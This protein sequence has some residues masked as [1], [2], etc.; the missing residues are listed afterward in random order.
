M[1]YHLAV[2]GLETRTLQSNLESK[3][4]HKISGMAWHDTP[5][6]EFIFNI[7][8]RVKLLFFIIKVANILTDLMF[9]VFIPQ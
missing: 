9:P 3:D 2:I 7:F 1:A 5:T 4:T 8:V 6:L